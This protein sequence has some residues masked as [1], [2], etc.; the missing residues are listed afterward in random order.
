MLSTAMVS[1]EKHWEHTPH[2]ADI[3]AILRFHFIRLSLPSHRMK[4]EGDKMEA[5]GRRDCRLG[6]KVEVQVVE[7]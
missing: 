6:M 3:D 2:G 1:Y 5:P 7:E 4:G